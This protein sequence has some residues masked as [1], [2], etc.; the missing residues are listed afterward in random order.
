MTAN[1]TGNLA[2]R[3]RRESALRTRLRCGACVTC[4]RYG[5]ITDIDAMR[6]KLE[7]HCVPATML[8]GVVPSLDD[9]LEQR[10]GLMALKIKR[11]FESL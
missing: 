7:A 9:F 6:R 4:R 11:W 5:G 8:E 3:N 1:C 10:R 2:E